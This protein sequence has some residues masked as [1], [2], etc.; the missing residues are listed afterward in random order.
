VAWARQPD[1][2]VEGRLASSF[3]RS[4]ATTGK[5]LISPMLG[6]AGDDVHAIVLGYPIVDDNAVVGALGLSVHLEALERVLASIPLPPGSVVTLT[7]A[8]SVVVARSLDASAYVGRSAAPGGHARNP[9]DVPCFRDP[10]RR[11]RRRTGLRQRCR[12][13]RPVAGQ[14]RHSDVRRDIAHVADLPAQFRNRRRCDGGHHRAVV[15]V[16]PAVAP[17][18][19]SSRRD[20]AARQ[21]GDMSGAADDADA[22]RGNG[23]GCNTP[24]A[25]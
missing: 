3:L 1:A 17:C 4:V 9:F 6:V 21:P 20:R 2:K 19:R 10:H 23:S 18:V 22:H 14:R 24:S 8:N 5:T 7:D 13:A 25:A 11:R 12:R 16:R 15:G